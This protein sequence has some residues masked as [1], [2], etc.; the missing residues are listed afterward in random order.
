M[1]IENLKILL[2]NAHSLVKQIA[3]FQSYIYASSFDIIAITETWLSDYVY[4]NEIL[5]NNFN[6]IRKD[7]DTRGGGV[8]LATLIPFKQLSA[9]PNTEM[10]SVEI[11]LNNR[12]HTICLI[13]RPPNTDESH[14]NNILAHLKSLNSSTDITI[15]SVLNL[16]DVCWDSYYRVS[17]RSQQFVNAAYNLNLSQLVTNPTHR[18]GNLLDVILSNA[19]TETFHDIQILLNLPPSLHY[20][21][22]F[23]TNTKIHSRSTGSKQ[24]FN[25]AAA[26][27]D[28][29]NQYLSC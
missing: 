17:H 14:D 16:P 7:H 22:I 25:Y 12:N 3:A 6:I 21:I 11:K 1:T 19:E 28:S 23:F 29:M 27:S 10:V 8:P 4:S 13:Y 26:D 9:L 15:L 20:M 24:V 2:W 18:A 5:P